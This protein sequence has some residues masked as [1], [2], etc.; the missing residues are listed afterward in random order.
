M[1]IKQGGSQWISLSDMMTWLMLVFLLI[2][3]LVISEIQE[4]EKEK[5]KILVEYSNV[6]DEIYKDLKKAFEEKEQDWDMSIDDDL[7]IKFSNPEV[8]FEA[9]SSR[10]RPSF[11][12]I[13]DEFVPQYLEIIDSKKYNNKIKEV[14]V[15]WHA[16]RCLDSE[17]WVCLKLSQWRA[18]SVVQNIFLNSTFKNFSSKQKQKMKFLFTSNGMSDGKNLDSWGEYI[19][20]SNSELDPWVSRR[21][22]FR[23]VTNSEELVDE[24]INKIK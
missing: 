8:L 21:V 6:K 24:L 18:N 19:Y 16:G 10:I 3:I 13:L 22:E 9:N 1:G 5:N 20:Y 14:R 2:S 15:E 23:I 17:Y 7:T 12:I 4:E 11:S